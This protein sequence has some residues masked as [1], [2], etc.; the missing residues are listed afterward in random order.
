MT[1]TEDR[2]S[3][4]I[5][6][7]AEKLR[8]ED[9]SLTLAESYSIAMAEDPSSTYAALGEQRPPPTLLTHQFTDREVVENLR[10]LRHVEG[11]GVTERVQGPLFRLTEE[12]AEPKPRGATSA[13]RRAVRKAKALSEAENISMP[14]ALDR[15]LSENPELF[16]E[17]NR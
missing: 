2:A 7:A 15:V 3:Q 16:E 5:E 1:T 6:A 17:A 9:R 10:I 12:F 11:G 8:R 4:R 14:A 13:E